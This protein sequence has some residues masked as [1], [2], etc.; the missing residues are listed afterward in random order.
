[1]DFYGARHGGRIG[2]EAAS[3]GHDGPGTRAGGTAG[4]RAPARVS[5]RLAGALDAIEGDGTPADRRGPIPFD[6]PDRLAYWR[7]KRE[8]EQSPGRG[9]R[10]LG[11]RPLR[12]QARDAGR[13]AGSRPAE[14]PPVPVERSVATASGANCG[15]GRGRGNRGGRGV[16]ALNGGGR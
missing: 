11:V 13:G 6:G 7:G 9:V 5:P 2:R 15:G 8:A 1:M 14:R 16:E 12:G 4:R 10:A 3:R